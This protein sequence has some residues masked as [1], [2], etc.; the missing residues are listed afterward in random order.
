MRMRT[1]GMTVENLGRLHGI[2]VISPG[3]PN[4]ESLNSQ[5]LELQPEFIFSFYYRSILSVELLSTAKIG[6]YNMHG[7]LL[8][9]YR[10]RVPINWAIIH[11]ETETGATLHEMVKKPDAGAIVSQMAVAILPNDTAADV[12]AKVL[13]AAELV[14]DR[15]LPPIINGTI[16]IVPMDLNKGS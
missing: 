11:G 1:Y 16:E 2:P 7:S 14:L 10:G 12:F 15:A 3:S 4:T 13:V 5:L 8:P 6:C 9:K